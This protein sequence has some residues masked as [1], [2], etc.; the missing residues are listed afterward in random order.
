[1][2]TELISRKTRREF[3]EWLV[4]SFLREIEDL[5]VS[6]NIECVDVPT[7][8]LPSGQRRSLVER[9]YAS[10]KWDK[11][12]DI[13]KILDVYEDILLD[14]PDDKKEYLVNLLK[15]DGYF[16][17][18]GRLFSDTVQGELRQAIRNA[19][20]DV[21]RLNVY[22]DR[23]K[24][25]VETDPALAIGSMKELIEATLKTIL[26]NKGITVGI[27]D[28]ISK[29]LRAVQKSLELAPE[30]IEDSKKGADTIRRILSNL[31]QIVVGVSELRN[32]YGTGHGRHAEHRGLGSRHARLVVGAGA[33]L[34][35]FLLETYGHRE[36]QA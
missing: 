5:F 9:Y 22:L 7:G 30:D 16:Y 34:C 2:V 36:N 18:D 25:S 6:H 26:S 1:M 31:G 24:A 17:E 27:G 28:D 19:S 10:I 11:P 15:R 4:G 20:L 23:I 29:L 3:R 33:T 14:I 32:L 12:T 35:I 8:Q 13:R 21:S